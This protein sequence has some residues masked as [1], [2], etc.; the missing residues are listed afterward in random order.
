MRP[1]KKNQ[2][3]HLWDGKNTL[4]RMWSTGGLRAK[5]KFGVYDSNMGRKICHMCRERALID[6]NYDMNAL[7]PADEM[8]QLDLAYEASLHQ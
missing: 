7:L 2:R 3:A 5:K 8:E 4:C 6:G 1:D